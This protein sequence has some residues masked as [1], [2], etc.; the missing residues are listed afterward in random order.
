VLRRQ[1]VPASQRFDPRVI[2]FE[3]L[4]R[5]VVLKPLPHVPFGGSSAYG[6]LGGGG[7]T[8]FCECP[9]QPESFTEINGVELQRAYS[10]AEQPR[11]QRLRPVNS[12]PRIPGSTPPF[13]RLRSALAHPLH[14]QSGRTTKPVMESS[15]HT[16]S[17]S[18]IGRMS[19]LIRVGPSPAPTPAGEQL[20]HTWLG[21]MGTASD[22]L[23]TVGSGFLSS[24]L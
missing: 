16:S 23:S 7:R 5:G 4:T 9:I 8:A 17:K 18:V 2:D 14:L 21:Q 13:E 12:G 22:I 1:P 3:Q 19:P 15:Q 24:R 11:P 20:A 6:Q 10:V